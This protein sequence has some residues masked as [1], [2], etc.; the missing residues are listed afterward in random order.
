M[1][2]CG[3]GVTLE[4]MGVPRDGNP[5]DE[6]MCVPRD[7]NPL[8]EEMGVPRDGNPLDEEMGVPRGAPSQL[9]DSMT[10]QSIDR[11]SHSRHTPRH[12]NSHR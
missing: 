6:D 7:G 4:E 3:V 5:L 8:D 10:L 11:S 2:R 1:G 9:V 12:G